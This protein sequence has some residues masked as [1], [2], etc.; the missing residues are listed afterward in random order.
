MDKLV[1]AL[2]NPVYD[3]IKTQI[4]D[5]KE[6]ILSGC[7]TNACLALSKMNKKS[8]LVGCIGPDYENT[9]KADLTSRGIDYL[10]YPSPE[11]GGFSLHY[12]DAYGNRDLKVLGTASPIPVA[13]PQVS[14]VSFVLIGPILGE[15]S[16]ELCTNIFNTISAPIMLDPQ[17][18]L[19]KIVNN[20]VVHEMSDDFL[21][22]SKMSFVIKANELETS[23]VTGI[24]PRNDPEEAV[25]ALYKFGCKI[26]VTTLAEAGSIIYDGKNLY[27]IPPFTTNAIDPTGAGDTFAAG[28]KTKYLETPDNLYEVGCFASSVSSIMVENVGPDFP[29]TR[30]EV[31]R[32]MGVLLS[33]PMKIK[34]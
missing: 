15:V 30:K 11:S 29:L 7:S 16:T 28:F 13:S 21:N 31:E 3:Y 4:V 10:L 9:L 1:L 18:L 17:G 33:G 24:N 19:R 23:V 25:K 2:G 5:T 34:L 22:I 6:R 32:R 14:N 8:M 26:A 27:Q 20:N 12:Y